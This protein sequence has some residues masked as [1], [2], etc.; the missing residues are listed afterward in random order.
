MS[1]RDY[2]EVLGVSKN[3]SEAELKKSYRRLAMKYHP[4]RNTGTEAKFKEVKEAYEVLSDAQKRAAYDQFGHA[5][6]DSSMGRGPGGPGGGVNFSDIFGDVFGDIFGGGR[7]GQRVNRGAD[8]RYNLELSLESAVAGTTV[9]IR[10]P[11]HKT[12]PTCRGS[13]AK[14][15]SKPETCTTCGGHGQ[16]RMQ[17]GFFS[18]QQTCPRCQGAG[19]IIKDPCPSC[20]GQGRV[21]ET[22]T[23]SVKV[24]PGVDTGDRIRLAGEGEAGE[25]G[26]PPG[27]LYVQVM[28]KDH[29]IFTREDSHLF[30]EVPI[31]F[32]TAALG[33]ELEVPTLDGKVVLKIPP[34]TQTGK[35]FRMRGKGIK[36]VRGG[37]VGD[38]ICRVVVETPVNLTERQKELLEELDETMQAGGRRHSP[39]STSWLAGVK[40]FF[41][42]MGF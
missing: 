16:V 25:H 30:C 23:L 35:S 33:G 15:G 29:E 5:G 31:S 21:Q 24:P 37:P 7:G 12:C 9:K 26:G 22:K 14:K 8:L 20:R 11:A 17:Q 28:V 42:G 38:L 1:K 6:V 40:K 10:V 13:G 19:T 27:D 41:E 4:D 34:G 3:A 36:P 2:Y 32:T 18:I 39:H